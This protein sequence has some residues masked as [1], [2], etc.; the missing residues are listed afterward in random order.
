MEDHK[1]INH[2]RE[3]GSPPKVIIRINKLHRSGVKEAEKI[4]PAYRA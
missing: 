4:L 3:V 2:K 1:G